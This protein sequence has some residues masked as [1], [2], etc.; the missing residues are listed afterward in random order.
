[1][2]GDWQLWARDDQLP[3]GEDWTTWLVL[4]GRGAGK[5]RAGAEWVRAQALGLYPFAS[6]P[7]MR[8]ALI[9]ET[10]GDV[11]SVM[12]E[13]VSGLLAVHGADERPRFEPSKRQL[14]W[15]ATGAVAQMFS[16]E[17]PESLRGPQFHAAWLD[18]LAKYPHPQRVWDM[19]QFGLRLGEMPQQVVTTTPRPI[20]LLKELLV[21]PKTVVSR[22]PTAANTANLAPAFLEGIVARYRGTR[23]GRQ[24]LDAE[25]LEDRPD[26]LWPRALIEQ[27][28]A[29]RP[30]PLERIVVA[31]DPPV[32][33]HKRSDACGLVVAGRAGDR[34]YVL[35]DATLEQARPAAWARAAVVAYHR[36][37]ADRLVAEVN[38]GGDM[39]ES[40][41]RQIDA[42]IPI[43]KVRAARGKWLRAEPVAALYE[44]GRVA[45]VGAFPKLEDQMADFGP[46]G[47]S[48]GASPDRVDALVWALTELM[49][50]SRANPRVRSL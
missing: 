25:I 9:G 22:A 5:T 16:A 23:L 44:Q 12:I 20:S 28:R 32:T 13:G 49:L 7:A 4:G 2:H 45:H 46:D 33:S 21:A 35:A 50:Q 27:S 1:M 6:E 3:Q 38:Q 43:R 39:V 42:T 18:E 37:G 14:T 34:A 29:Q 40:V 31:V 8:I 36:Y 41:I 47:L 19:L 26:A 15:P 48:G 24:E 30:P 10:L 17:D 11:R